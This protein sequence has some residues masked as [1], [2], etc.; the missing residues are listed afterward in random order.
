MKHYLLHCPSYLTPS[1]IPLSLT[2]GNSIRIS[3]LQNTTSLP[4]PLRAIQNDGI[5]TTVV[6]EEHPAV[7]PEAPTDASLLDW[8]F[9]DTGM[10]LL[11]ALDR[12]GKIVLELSVSQSSGSATIHVSSATISRA[13]Q[14]FAENF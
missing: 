2:V 9:K 6:D 7:I 1:S 5:P 3:S 10:S 14:L 11:V 13:Y 12:I 4:N 8:L